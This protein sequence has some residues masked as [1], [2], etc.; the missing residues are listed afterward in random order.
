AYACRSSRHWLHMH[1]CDTVCLS[2]SVSKPHSAQPADLPQIKH[3]SSGTCCCSSGFSPFSSCSFIFFCAVSHFSS[4][5]ALLLFDHSA[6]SPGGISLPH[7]IHFPLNFTISLIQSLISFS[8]SRSLLLLTHQLI[9]RQSC[10]LQIRS[11]LSFLRSS[12]L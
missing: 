9:H 12:A 2:Q 1:A 7:P 10:P 4:L 11:D 6:Y 8:P 3:S 5:I